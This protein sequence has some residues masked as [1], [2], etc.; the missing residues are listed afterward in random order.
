MYMKVYDECICVWRGYLSKHCKPSRTKGKNNIVQKTSTS[1]VSHLYSSLQS[2]PNAYMMYVIWK[3]KGAT[4]IIWQREMEEWKKIWHLRM[5]EHFLRCVYENCW[6][7]CHCPYMVRTIKVANFQQHVECHFLTFV[8]SIK[9]DSTITRL[10]LMWDSYPDQSLTRL[11]REKGGCRFKVQGS[12]P[13]PG[14]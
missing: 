5:A 13:I 11:T 8:Q 12:T 14:D 3:S 7:C 10:D 2:R 1:M 6:C 4:I 9:S